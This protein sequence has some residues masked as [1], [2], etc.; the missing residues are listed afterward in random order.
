MAFKKASASS[1]NDDCLETCRD[2]AGES[3][4]TSRICPS[5]ALCRRRGLDTS[6]G[7]KLNELSRRRKRRVM[8]CYHWVYRL[9]DASIYLSEVK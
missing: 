3:N 8:F 4:R 9:R 2:P 5:S 6:P 1:A 7:S